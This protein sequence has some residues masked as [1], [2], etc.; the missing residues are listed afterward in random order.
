[1]GGEEIG[2]RG[3]YRKSIVVMG[4]ASKQREDVRSAK[5]KLHLS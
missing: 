4:N 3:K 1:M 2:R 5:I